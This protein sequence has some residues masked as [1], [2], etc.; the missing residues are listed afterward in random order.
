MADMP[1]PLKDW[2]L[3]RRVPIALIVSLILQ[4]VI[5]GMWVGGIQE[6][7][8]RNERDIAASQDTGERLARL[9]ALL[10]TILARLDRQEQRP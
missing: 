2:H 7:V 4:T 1:G 9:E 5:L 10:E 3:D 8:A 6:R